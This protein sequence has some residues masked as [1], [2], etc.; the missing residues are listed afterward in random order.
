MSRGRR[1][2]Y[3]RRDDADRHGEAGPRTERVTILVDREER[4]RWRT[5]ASAEQLTL[6]EWLRI[7]A[8]HAAEE[9]T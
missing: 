7:Q 5:A 1:G 9:G 8:H 4:D 2:R 3:Q 6:S